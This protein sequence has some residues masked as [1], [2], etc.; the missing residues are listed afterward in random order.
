M[1]KLY[2]VFSLFLL[3]CSISFGQAAVDIALS[4]TDGTITI[5]LSVGLDLTATNCIDPALGESDLPPFPPPGNFEIRFDL[6]PY[7]CP[8]LTT[9]RDYRNAPA[10]PYTGT[11]QHTLWWQTSSAGLPI[12]INY[13]LPTGASITITDQVNGSFLNL[14]PFTGTGT[15]TIPGSYTA[16]FAKAYMSMV[17]DNIGPAQPGPVFSVS[18]Q[19]L[20]FGF[21][22]IGNPS[23]MQLV[24]SNPGTTNSMTLTSAS[25]A[26]TDYTV[27]PNPPASFPIII[28]AQGSYTFDV[29][30]NP[31]V[32]G[33][34]SGDVVFVSDA[35]GSPH[36]VPVTGEGIE[37]KGLTWKNENVYRL[38]D[39]SF[40]DTLQLIAASYPI[41]ALQFTI[42][43]NQEI[44]DNT[45]LSFLNIQK[46]S[47]IADPNWV[48][49]Y[50]VVRGPITGNGASQDV[51]YVV[52]YN[53]TTISLPA[54]QNYNDLLRVNYRVA[55][56][57]AL[58][59]TIPSTMAI[60]NAQGSTY[61]G[62]PVDITPSPLNRGTLTVFGLNT[63]S[64]YGDVNGDGCIDILDL[65]LVVDHIVGR[66]SLTG[67]EFTRAD[68][69]P[70]PT[71]ASEPNPD[72]FVNVMDL[73]LLQ[74]IILEGQYPDGLPVAP[75]GYAGLSKTNGDA[76]ATVTLYINKTG[77]TA[78]LDSKI[79]IRG[80]QLEF[81]SVENDP[82]DMIINTELGQGFYTKVNELLRTLMYD[83]SAQKYI[84]AGE[85]FMADMPFTISNPENITMDKLILVDIN[86]Q[87]VLKIEVNIN[88]GTPTL[89]YDY[90]LY[91]NYPNP[92][93]PS[94][95]V[96]FQIPQ[97]SDVTIKI[98]DMLGQEVRTLFSAQ[99]MRGTYT[100]NWDG[101]NNAGTKMSS[102]SYFYRMTA[103]EFTQSKKMILL[104]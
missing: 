41:H 83:R 4:G 23:T 44:G 22:N 36:L 59:D 42:Y 91:Q 19:S 93:N 43:T 80:A 64:G 104:K 48:L 98:Y 92:F 5:P 20:D 57:P 77:I 35:P 56:L 67:D 84:D 69:A 52:V 27:V 55:N 2:S 31:A 61:E 18:P 82:G 21:V 39:N 73:S 45:I 33:V 13:N 100:V 7:G 63:K 65:I 16:I 60:K 72:G 79:A 58:Q 66:D 11:I 102:G 10:F 54:G 9:Y 95:S 70:W 88:Y 75:C 86:R 78:Y 85:H 29:T 34:S 101:M 81:G 14:G 38:E 32:V 28:P 50:N 62:N 103:G 76:D 24:V 12:N 99:V 26:N 53:T 8:A 6:A 46:G 15:A 1:R 68:I 90:I 74:W 94:T 51:I 89:P 40:R 49:D 3:F 30:F 17:Y 71:G 37:L 25:I 96:K 97:T 87:K 47:N